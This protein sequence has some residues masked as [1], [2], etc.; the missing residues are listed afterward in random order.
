MIMPAKKEESIYDFFLEVAKENLHLL[1]D[2]FTDES[3]IRDMKRLPLSNYNEFVRWVG[4]KY[5]S[6]LM[7]KVARSQQET[8]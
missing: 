6:H 4:I 7:L 1:E 8:K 2:P 3:L 5:C